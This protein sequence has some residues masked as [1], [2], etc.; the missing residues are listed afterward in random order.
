MVDHDAKVADKTAEGDVT[1]K[2]QE[3]QT[4]QEILDDAAAKTDT[5]VDYDVTFTYTITVKATDTCNAIGKASNGW[6]SRQRFSN[7]MLIGADLAE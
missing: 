7:E 1:A 6:N 3:G 5:P 2:N 4:A